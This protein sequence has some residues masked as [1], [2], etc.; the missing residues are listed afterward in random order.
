MQAPPSPRAKP[1]FGRST[2]LKLVRPVEEIRRE[3]LL[4]LIKEA[5]NASRLSLQTGVPSSYISQVSRGVDRGNGKPRTMG[6]D[7]ARKLEVA[8]GKPTGWMDADHSAL[9]IASD[10]SGREGQLVGL[11]RLLTDAEQID[12]VNGL[13]DRLKLGSVRRSDDDK[14]PIRH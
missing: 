9:S 2:N 8:M 4:T 11:F 1:H 10:L 7:I 5:G 13:T 3:N 6:P 14:D 12:L